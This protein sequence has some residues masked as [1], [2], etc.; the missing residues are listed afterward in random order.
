[1]VWSKTGNVRGQKGDNGTPG[2]AAT[3]TV[4]TTN[5]GAAGSNASVTNSGTASA[6]VFNFSV[7]RGEKGDTGTGTLGNIYGTTMVVQLSIITAEQFAALT[8]KDINTLY[9]VF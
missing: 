2:T 9:V 6:A 4:G 3:I 5:T 7:P 1:M 8:T